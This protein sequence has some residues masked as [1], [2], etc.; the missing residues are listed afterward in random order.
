MRLPD[1]G[2]QSIASD[3]RIVAEPLGKIACTNCGIVVRPQ[4]STSFETGYMLYA[5]DPGRQ[6]E[7]ERQSKYAQWIAENVGQTPRRILDVGCGN[8]SLLAAL[9]RVW[10]DAELLGCDPSRDAV[11]YAPEHVRAWQGTADSLP[12]GI[13]ADLVVSV[14]V[15]EHTRDPVAFV[16]GVSAACGAEGTIAL[17]CPNG[18]APGVELLFADHLWS[19]TSSHL[20]AIARR[21]GAGPVRASLAPAELGPF[22][23][24]TAARRQPE[25]EA[26]IRGERDLNLARA[27]YLER[28][29]A[30]D[31]H[32]LRRL[33]PRVICFGAG[34]AS[35]LL[36]AY[37]PRTWERV[38]ACTADRVDERTFGGRPVLPIEAVPAATTIL[39]GVRPADQERVA[40]RLR[41]NYHDVITWYDLVGEEERRPA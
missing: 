27:R 32:L 16:R 19:F 37:A 33:P 26:V 4:A 39:V 3:L 34:E 30:L 12:A 2:P 22:Q 17:V 40:A 29:R 25:D 38:D 20:C 8:G 7:D 35:G 23:M 41:A 11:L 36:R 10:P 18:G 28:W 13:D 9:G 14:N 1:P 6:L 31:E 5:H 21:G 15:L 24:I